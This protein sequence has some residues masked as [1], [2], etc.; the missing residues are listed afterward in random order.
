MTALPLVAAAYDTPF[1]ELNVLATS[2]DGV[3]RAA[4]FL[5]VQELAARVPGD[6]GVLGWR[7]GV[8]PQVASAVSAWVDG[9][10]DALSAVDVEQP[11]GPFFQ[12][13]WATLRGVPGGE[14]VSY[15]E[16]AQMAGRPRAMR[17]VGTAC[18]RNAVGV[19]VPCHRVIQSSG[20]LGGYGF[21]GTDIKKAMLEHEGL[22][23]T[24]DARVTLAPTVA[25]DMELGTAGGVGLEPRL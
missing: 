7:A 22:R 14:V 8:L 15:Q 21:G 9:D 20:R 25:V 3:V 19:F 10:V 17:A 4:G 2:E 16:L 12:E 6:I 24:A 1:G 18:A 11:G 23:V 5:H 13:V